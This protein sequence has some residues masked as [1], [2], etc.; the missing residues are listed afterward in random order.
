MFFLDILLFILKIYS[1][2]RLI[3]PCNRLIIYWDVLN[4]FFLSLYLFYIPLKFSF[5]FTLSLTENPLIYIFFEIFPISIFLIDILITLNSGFYYK[6]DLIE[7]KLKILDNYYK[8]N[9]LIDLISLTPFFISIR[10]DQKYIEILFFIRI[11]KIQKLIIKIEENLN[12]SEKLKGIFDL[13]KLMFF[14]TYLAHFFGC[15]YYSLADFESKLGKSNWI[16]KHG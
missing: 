7:D 12:F 6:G 16:D 14:V 1:K 5:D 11:L 10:F 2:I 9:F 15:I 13:I 3:S 8:N 4:L